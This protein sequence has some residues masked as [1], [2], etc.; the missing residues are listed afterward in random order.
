MSTIT[1][2]CNGDRWISAYRAANLLARQGFAPIWATAAFTAVT[3]GGYRSTFAAGTLL[4][5]TDQ[6][7]SEIESIIAG[8][9][10]EAIPVSDADEIVGRPL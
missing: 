3:E 7:I 8:V 4:V 2:R 9:G 1:L 5:T 6:S 10:A